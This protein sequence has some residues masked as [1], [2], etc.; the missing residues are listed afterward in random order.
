MCVL[1]NWIMQSLVCPHFFSKVIEE[2]PLRGWLG[3]GRT[4]IFLLGGSHFPA[5]NLVSP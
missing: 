3:K 5:H 4:I 1:L 2:K